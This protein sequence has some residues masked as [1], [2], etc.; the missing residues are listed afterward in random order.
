ML[1]D[2]VHAVWKEHKVPQEWENA[3]LIPIPK[4]GNLRVCDNWR[5][6][7][8]LD[9]A[10]KLVGRIVQDHLQGLAE[11]ELPESQC[12]FRRGCGCMDMIFMGCRLSEKAFEHN[13]KQF[14]CLTIQ[15]HARLFGLFY[16]G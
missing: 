15:F 9:V 16:R 11:V 6:I 12:G 14:F 1:T 4:K 5:G 3:I 7:A 2:L 8:L 13:T 10:G